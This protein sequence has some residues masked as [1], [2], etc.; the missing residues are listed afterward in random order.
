[1]VNRV[2][3]GADRLVELEDS[4]L[5]GKRLGL[6]TNP[7]GITSDFEP[8]VQVCRRLK[9]ARLT[10]LFACEHGIRGERQAGVAF[11]DETDPDTGI[12]VFSLYG[13]R[14]KPTADLLDHVD[15]L[16]F[17]IQDLGVRFYTYLTTLIYT[18][19]ACEASGTELI[20]LDRPNPLGGIVC[21]GGLLREGFE[22]MV[23]GASVPIRTGLTIG[24]LAGFLYADR[25]MSFPFRVVPLEGWNRRMEYPDTG[26]PW[27]MP[28]PN[29]PA[30]DSVRVYPGTCLLEGTN[31][32]EGRGTTRPFEMIGA[33][34][35]DGRELSERLNGRKLPGLR[36]VP[37]YYTP[38]FSKYEKELC[39]GIRLFVTDP[40]AYR[41]VETGLVLLHEIMSLYP[42]RFEWL[43]PFKEGRK[44]FI[45]YL[46]GGDR[47]RTTL[48][49]KDGLAALSQDWRM[50]AEA[51]KE[52]TAP[53]YLYGR[54]E[55][56]A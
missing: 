30:M 6:L 14:K 22:S 42:G 7:T 53:F 29:M 5:K 1:M 40:G 9:S 38:T 27:L 45:D 23:G 16:L 2:R 3:T 49:D 55:Q 20:V 10:A 56:D 50:E 44:P 17:D 15:A 4:M 11:G 34:W 13:E 12:P 43:S 28:S 37:L 36:T 39:G 32:S 25:G 24:E 51:W 46:T 47:V 8:T 18:M 48:A 54:M 21:E 52:R 33:P 41:P 26:L 31:V 19:E 35:L